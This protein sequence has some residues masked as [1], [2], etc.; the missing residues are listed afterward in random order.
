MNM[1]FPQPVLIVLFTKLHRVAEREGDGIHSQDPKQTQQATRALSKCCRNIFCIS[2]V[3]KGHG[4]QIT[5]EASHKSETNDIESLAL[6]PT[7]K[8]IKRKRETENL[9]GP[10]RSTLGL[11]WGHSDH[12]MRVSPKCPPIGPDQRALLFGCKQ[13]SLMIYDR[14]SFGVTWGSNVK[15][16]PD[17]SE[18]PP[19]DC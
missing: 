9:F 3:T 11:G 12:A 16:F 4:E 8:D 7:K 15:I 13:S 2:D 19:F 1:P 6:L 10:T 18:H 5:L 17:R 14:L